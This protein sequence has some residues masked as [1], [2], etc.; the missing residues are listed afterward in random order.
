MQGYIFVLKSS[1][2]DCSSRC[3]FDNSNL[4][5]WDRH[6]RGRE[7]DG[8]TDLH[9]QVVCKLHSKAKFAEESPP[10]VIRTFFLHQTASFSLFS[11]AFMNISFLQLYLYILYMEYICFAYTILI[12]TKLARRGVS[13]RL[14]QMSLLPYNKASLQLLSSIK[15]T[16]DPHPITCKLRHLDLDACMFA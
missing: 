14:K 16:S 10:H 8:Q 15:M 3:R 11:F 12:I 1:F 7:T 9:V 13:R 6:Q 4:L 2:K 5:V